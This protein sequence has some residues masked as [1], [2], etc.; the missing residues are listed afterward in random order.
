MKIS[1][2]VNNSGE[3]QNINQELA[4]ICNNLHKLE[5]VNWHSITF[6]G[7]TGSGKSKLINALARL[8][9]SIYGNDA[10]LELHLSDDMT[11][12]KN[13]ISKIKDI[14]VILIDDIH[15]LKNDS[16]LHDVLFELY[17]FIHNNKRLIIMS[18]VKHPVKECKYYSR[19]AT[20]FEWGWLGSI[21][22]NI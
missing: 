1:G 4:E 16:E 9:S 10:V 2:H 22:K 12:F 11:L 19:L 5:S 8:S 6:Y 3:Y 18:S 7:S 15:L 13:V 20:R 17:N 21:Q 14:K